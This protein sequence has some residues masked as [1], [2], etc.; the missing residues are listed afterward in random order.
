ML[1]SNIAQYIMKTFGINELNGFKETRLNDGLSGAEVYIL[2]ILKPRRKRDHGIYVLKVIDTLS[3]WYNEENNEAVR[4]K[5]LCDEA[6]DFQKHLVKVEKNAV[7]DHKLILILSF[8]LK[9]EVSTISL[10][11]IR[12]DNKLPLLEQIS[13]DLL[14]E[15]NKNFINLNYSRQYKLT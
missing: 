12:L 1:S 4:S 9:S 7:V 2:E 8:A 13:Y 3:E 11:R 5:K 10:E 6:A 14:K 15:L